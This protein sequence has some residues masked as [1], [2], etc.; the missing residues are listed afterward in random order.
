MTSS[1]TFH[2][3][4]A[5]FRQPNTHKAHSVNQRMTFSRE[6]SVLKQAQLSDCVVTMVMQ[7]ARSMS[8]LRYRSRLY[9]EPVRIGEPD[10]QMMIQMVR[11]NGPLRALR[12][13]KYRGNPR[14]RPELVQRYR[15]HEVR[16]GG[17]YL[18][19][20]HLEIRLVVIGCG[21]AE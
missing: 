8:P 3:N 6:M 13:R 17:T 10:V 1:R 14:L 16:C 9:P 18:I 21:L 20:L 11:F 2:N 5:A 19:L 15:S 4:E 7:Y 12:S